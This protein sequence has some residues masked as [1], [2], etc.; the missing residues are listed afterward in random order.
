M[1]DRLSYAAIGLVLGSL[2]AVLLWLFF[3]FSFRHRSLTPHLDIVTW[4]KYLGG[5]GAVAGFIL[6]ERVGDVLGGAVHTAYDIETSPS[7]TSEVPTWLVVVVLALVVVSVW[8][9]SAR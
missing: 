3:G 1:R 4:L 9:F 7:R 8:F 5:G 6:K 2:V